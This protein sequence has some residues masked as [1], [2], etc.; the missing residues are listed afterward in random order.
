MQ[1]ASASGPLFRRLSF[2]ALVGATALAVQATSQPDAWIVADPELTRLLR[3]MAFLKTGIVAAAAAAVLWRLGFPISPGRAA[4][5][6]AGV[7]MMAG[8]SVWIW[9]PSS[10]A[11]AALGFHAGIAT[12]LVAAGVDGRERGRRLAGSGSLIPR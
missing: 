6:A 4:L 2:L 5:Y 3:G 8:A 9:L 7:A 12:V 11:A 1:T 10:I